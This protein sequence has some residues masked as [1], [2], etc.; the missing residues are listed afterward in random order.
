[1]FLSSRGHGL[2]AR[3]EFMR[4]GWAVALVPPRYR[5]KWIIRLLGKQAG[6]SR[7]RNTNNCRWWKSPEPIRPGFDNNAG[8]GGV[9]KNSWPATFL[10]VKA[11]ALGQFAKRGTKRHECCREKLLGISDDDATGTRGAKT[12]PIAL[13]MLSPLKTTCCRELL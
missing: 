10:V 11:N 7:R 5:G 6:N 2:A 1:M 13:L 9:S 4:T 8:G 12:A 3:G